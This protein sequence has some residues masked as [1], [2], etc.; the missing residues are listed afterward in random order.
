MFWFFLVTCFAK[1]GKSIERLRGWFLLP[2]KLK[3]MNTKVGFSNFVTSWVWV[4][5]CGF[6]GSSFWDLVSL[7][8]LYYFSVAT[9]E[10]TY[11]FELVVNVLSHIGDVVT[12]TCLTM[13]RF[14]IKITLWTNSFVSRGIYLICEITNGGTNLCSNKGKKT[15]TLTFWFFLIYKEARVLSNLKIQFWRGDDSLTMS[16][17]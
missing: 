15:K 11:N 5:F 8:I 13:V 17:P 14:R 10:T 12:V 3:V 6:N 16:L 7:P 4:Q 2:W 1:F 9:I